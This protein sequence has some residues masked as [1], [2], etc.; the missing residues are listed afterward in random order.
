M[1]AKKYLIRT[2]I[3]SVALFFFHSSIAQ[4]IGFSKINT[5]G[6]LFKIERLS[7][8]KY[9]GISTYGTAQGISCWD[10]HFNLLWY[11]SF[12]S[13]E[14]VPQ[15]AIQLNNEEIVLLGYQSNNNSTVMKF[16]TAGNMLFSK[17]YFYSTS[18]SV[19]MNTIAPAVTGDNGYIM[20]GNGCGG[21]N[22]LVKCDN[23]GAILWSNSY[24]TSNVRSA[25][26]IDSKSDGY[27]VASSVFQGIVSGAAWSD[28]SIMKVD[29]S[30]AL[31]WC[32]QIQSASD[33]EE[34]KQIVRLSDNRFALL[35]RYDVTGGNNMIYFFDSTLTNI[36]YKK[37]VAPSGIAINSIVPN[38][39]GGVIG[40]GFLNT[41]YYKGILFNTDSS[42]TILW[43]KSSLGKSGNYT[44]F[45]Q[46]IIKSHGSNYVIDGKGNLEPTISV[47]DELGNGFCVSDTV[48]ISEIDTNSFSVTSPGPAVINIPITVNAI[49]DSNT[50]LSFSTVVYCGIL[51][52]GAIEN[53]IIDNI[54]ITPNPTNGEI[55]ID[56]SNYNSGKLKI[57]IIN[58]LGQ[59]V[60]EKSN[61]QNNEYLNIGN[62]NNGI[63]YLILS[64]NS[65][66]FTKKIVV[67][68]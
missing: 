8:N 42:G 13:A 37:Y 63:Y 15:Q 41:S 17:N 66:Q 19:Q 20:A 59:S 25:V 33:N 52:T 34:P 61:I 6:F 53:E 35:C 43:K 36:T 54:I 67:Q 3:I 31:V 62:I 68:K 60:F 38:S 56:L 28:V 18:Y 40:V 14:F 22:I 51:T 46:D 44:S 1:K 58:I 10:N 49:T 12:N 29:N 23:N 21:Q 2:L 39:I 50:T 7:T 4:N 26:S 11:K 45:Y 64:N 32:K 57:N 30:G 48:S 24:Y 55:N 16:D 47:I 65:T 5:D 9:I 27:V